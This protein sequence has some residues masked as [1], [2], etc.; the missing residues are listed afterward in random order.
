MILFAFAHATHPIIVISIIQVSP[1]PV[2]EIYNWVSAHRT[3]GRFH[4]PD[5]VPVVYN[6]VP[7]HPD[8][9]PALTHGCPG[10]VGNTYTCMSVRD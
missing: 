8:K 10:Y 3:A 9:V 6:L 2:E 7:W 5:T 4:G 1:G